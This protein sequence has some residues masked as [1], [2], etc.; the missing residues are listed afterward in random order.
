MQLIVAI[1]NHIQS[2]IPG[3]VGRYDDHFNANCAGDHF[4]SKEV[5][6]LLFEAG[7]YPADYQ[8][9]ETRRFVYEALLAAAQSIATKSY[10]KNSVRDYL[11]IPENQKDYFDLK[12]INAHLINSKISAQTSLTFQ[13]VEVLEAGEITFIP[14]IN[15]LDDGKEYYFHKL[16]DFS[17]PNT[18]R[19]EPVVQII[20]EIIKDLH[21]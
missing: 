6:T 14:K 15:S 10:L 21:V 11:L 9:E 2:L 20:T 18:D 16:I 1:N 13:Y 4:Q 5:P 8:R 19:Q 12:V 3:Q 7:H 17:L